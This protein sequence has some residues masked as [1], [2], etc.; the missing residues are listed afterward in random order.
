[1]CNLLQAASRKRKKKERKRCK[2]NN[3]LLLICHSGLT[4][5]III[6]LNILKNTE[7]GSK[8]MRET[9]LVP[10]YCLFCAKVTYTGRQSSV[11]VVP[12]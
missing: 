8:I 9:K 1:M 10:K 5:Y 11:N 2:F 6:N 3:Q 12:K 7:I 4:K